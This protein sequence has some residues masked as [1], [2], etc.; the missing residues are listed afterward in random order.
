MILVD[1]SQVMISNLMV[2]VHTYNKN[3]EID[4]GRSGTKRGF[5]ERTEFLATT[6]RAI[7]ITATICL[8]GVAI[9]HIVVASLF[10]MD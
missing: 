8:F 5:F 1:F 4:E 10:G 2:A 9:A 7:H 3:A 6:W